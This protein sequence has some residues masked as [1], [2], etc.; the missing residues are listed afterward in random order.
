MGD[1]APVNGFN[2]LSIAVP[3]SDDWLISFIQKDGTSFHRRVSPSTLSEESARARAIAS[4]KQPE[5]FYAAIHIR[6]M[7]D[8]RI[9]VP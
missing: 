5:S 6:R 4:T 1:L 7:S 8:R 2:P 9:V 3:T